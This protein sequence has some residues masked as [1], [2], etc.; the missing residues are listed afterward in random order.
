M[1]TFHTH[2]R[3]SGLFHVTQSVLTLT[4]AL[5]LSLTLTLAMAPGLIAEASTYNYP[6]P[7]AQSKKGIAL[8]ADMEEDALELN[9]RHTTLNFPLTEFIAAKSEQNDTVS[10]PYQ[11]GGTTYWFRKARVAAAD[12][13]LTKMKKNDTIVTGILLL[14][15]RNDMLKLIYPRARR[16]KASFY[17][18]N[19][20]GGK[21]QKTLEAA[22]SFLANRYASG[23]NGRVVGWIVSNEIDSADEWNCAGN[24]SF[25]T[26]MDLYAKMFEMTSRIVRDV[27]SNARVYVPLDHFWNIIYTNNFK[28]KDCLDGFAARMARDGV[29][30]NVAFHAYNGDLMQPSITDEQYFPTTGQADT[31]II[32]MKNLGVLTDYIR[33]N[34]G[35][36]KRVILSEHGYSSTWKG[37]EDQKAQAR[38]VALSYYLA[39]EN[40]MV[41]SF[42]YYSQVDQTPLTK[43]GAS[44]GLWKVS[45]K[46]KATDKKK[47]WATFKYMDTDLDNPILN[48]ARRISTSMT[49]QAA[50]S[51]RSI[52]LKKVKNKAGKP[53]KPKVKLYKGW[54]VCGAVAGVRKVKHGVMLIHD[55]SRNKNVSWGIQ[56][57]FRKLNAKKHP[58][59]VFRVKGK[60]LSGP[61]TELLV[62]VFSGDSHVFEASGKLRSGSRSIKVDLRKWPYRNAVT[63]IQILV[64]R[65]YGGVKKGASVTVSGIGLR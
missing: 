34:F 10:Y 18:W 39:E 7:T 11:Y 27:Y 21:N 44:F 57:S 9:V 43:V 23:E 3:F 37:K 13:T 42:I 56:R 19:M 49:G 40:P 25:D 51:T 2:S 12:K 16:S 32:T 24:V 17:A 30:W 35:E 6:Y 53:G 65:S 41:D 54:Q 33:N 29:P 38:S 63:G 62:R 48:L 50:K 45:K 5:T 8:G 26:Y 59:L 60:K 52:Q 58:Y 1:I 46:E 4:L 20:D 14:Q 55:A 36:D 22:I 15:K 64:K 31:P 61:G 47:S 28:A